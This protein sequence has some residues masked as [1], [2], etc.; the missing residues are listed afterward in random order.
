MPSS[1]QG[2]HRPF[3]DQRAERT[4]A[5]RTH[6]G[7]RRRGALNQDGAG[8]KEGRRPR[9]LVASLSSFLPLLTDRGEWG[10][11]SFLHLYSTVETA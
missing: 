2:K 3:R 9:P 11:S 10:N 8:I 5:G 7:R 1:V 6:E 4:D